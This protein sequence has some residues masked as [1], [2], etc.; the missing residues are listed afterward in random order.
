MRARK[1]SGGE[2]DGRR[3]TGKKLTQVPGSEGAS[4]PTQDNLDP[5][6]LDGEGF[7]DSV[8]AREVG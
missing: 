6:P 1:R 3:V 2:Q 5:L 8:F 4:L 7:I